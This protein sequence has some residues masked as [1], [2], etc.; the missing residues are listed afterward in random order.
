VGSTFIWDDLEET[1]T[2]IGRKEILSKLNK[3]ITDDYTIVD[4]NAGIRPAMPD[5]RPVMGQHP[6]YPQM[7]IFNGMGTKGVSLS[8]YFAT[9]FL[10]SIDNDT[11][12][13]REISVKRFEV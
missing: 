13:F 5:R 6:D 12:V 11:E 9:Y 10:D 3:I 2:D 8:P 7:Y 4:E 1:V